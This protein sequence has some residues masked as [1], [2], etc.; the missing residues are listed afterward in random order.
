MKNLYAGLRLTGDQKVI[1]HYESYYKNL[2]MLS[3]V[4]IKTTTFPLPDF[5]DI[6]AIKEYYFF[7]WIIIKESYPDKYKRI[8][9][10]FTFTRLLYEHYI[11]NSP[12]EVATVFAVWYYKCTLEMEQDDSYPWLTTCAVFGIFM[13]GTYKLGNGVFMLLKEVLTAD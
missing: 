3:D 11:R 4:I 1:P 8:A 6:Q 5:K 10:L 2:C 9:C 12:P 7:Q 13:F